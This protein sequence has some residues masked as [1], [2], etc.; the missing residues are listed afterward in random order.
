MKSTLK[1][2]LFLFIGF[3]GA[4]QNVEEVSIDTLKARVAD[5][6]IYK[7][8][9]SLLDKEVELFATGELSFKGVDMN[10]IKIHKKDVETE[11]QLLKVYEN[12]G[13]KNAKKYI[14]VSNGIMAKYS[15]LVD[16]YYR[17][18]NMSEAERRLFM[19]SIKIPMKELDFEKTRIERKKH[20]SNN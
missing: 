7:E 5:D 9:N 13:M 1:Y 3:T 17:L 10:Y 18:A 14:E 20:L 8:Y 12:A 15:R 6:S 2:L 19:K 11:E 4:C 16:K